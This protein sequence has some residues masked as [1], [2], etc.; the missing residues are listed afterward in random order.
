MRLT[1]CSRMSSLF[2]FLHVPSVAKKITLEF[3]NVAKKEQFLSNQEGGGGS[4][5][6]R[7]HSLFRES[8]L[9]PSFLL[10]YISRIKNFVIKKLSSIVSFSMDFRF[11]IFMR[12]NFVLLFSFL[13]A[14]SCFQD[15][16][17]FC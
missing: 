9:L 3:K 8:C 11:I 13:F 4:T 14:I 12:K 16:I 6:V 1:L 2:A 15:N 7:V 5:Q 10:I 17:F